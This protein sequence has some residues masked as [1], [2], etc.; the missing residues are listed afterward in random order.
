[1]ILASPVRGTVRPDARYYPAAPNAL[2]RPAGNHEPLVTQDFGP[3]SVAAEPTVNWPGGE[4]D[5]MGRPIPAGSY[6]NFHVG[7]DI[8]MAGCGYDVLA[9]GPGKVTTS[10]P[11]A[12]G[13][14]VV[15][16]DHGQGFATRYVHLASRS[17]AV[18][19]MVAKGQLVGKM[20]D[21]GLSTGCHLHFALTRNGDPVDPWRRLAQNTTTDP[22]QEDEMPPITTYIPGS[23]ALIS[24]A[25]GDVN[26]RDAA[27]GG[28]VVRQ[29]PKG[30]SE[31]WT[32]TGW[33]KGD[34]AAGSDQWL[35]RW[36]GA[37]EYVHK[38]NV[39]SVTAP[40]VDCTAQVAAATKAGYQDAKAKAG[41]AVAAI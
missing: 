21:T 34:T 27:T 38:I 6:S 9:A 41:A 10:A 36:A 15:V 5:I 2:L 23:V 28:K 32:V 40:A 39:V 8:S 3:T 4:S 26:V 35:T 1:M 18:G 22:D 29:I 37:W 25:N 11:N 12:S 31:S 30:Q 16:I 17:V 14:Q 7:I 19:A 33:V 20:G 24:N 13:A